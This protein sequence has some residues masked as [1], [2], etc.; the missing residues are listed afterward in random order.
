MKTYVLLIRGLFSMGSMGALAPGILK[1]ELLAPAILG[2]S[3]TVSTHKSKFLNRPL[4][5]L[6][7]ATHLDNN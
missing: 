5:F 7:N 6:F 4:Y 3:I 2:Q 1:I